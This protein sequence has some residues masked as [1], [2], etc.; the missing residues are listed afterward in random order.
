MSALDVNKDGGGESSEDNM[1]TDQEFVHSAS[2]TTSAPAAPAV[3]MEEGNSAAEVTP[4]SSTAPIAPQ[5]G[6]AAAPVAPPPTPIN[7]GC[8]GAADI[9]SIQIPPSSSVSPSKN[10]DFSVLKNS[11]DEALAS[12]IDKPNVGTPTTNG[13]GGEKPSPP[14]GDPEKKQAQLRAMYLAGFRAAAEARNHQQSL[15]ANFENAKNGNA[16]VPSTTGVNNTAA[17]ANGTAQAV[18]IPMDSNVA[19]GVIAVQPSPTLAAPVASASTGATP[20][21]AGLRTSSPIP[22]VPPMRLSSSL[23]LPEPQPV[24]SSRRVTRTAS[25]NI[26]SSPAA[27]SSASTS[28]S[29]TSTG[30]HSNPF[31]RKLMEM[32]RKE[33]SSVV[34]WLPRGDAFAV[35]DAD[36]FVAEVLPRYF[37]HTKVGESCITLVA[38]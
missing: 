16:S 33:D 10:L 20:L 21:M 37:R 4:V 5:L 7:M 36:K 6:S 24:P 26:S 14:S 13:G 30:G 8:T 25:G 18:V 1:Q 27:I 9:S 32:L 2:G 23:P 29:T 34:S 38:F 35:R 31:P 3:K 17:T 15:K 28:P 22:P 11:M 12:I 19:A